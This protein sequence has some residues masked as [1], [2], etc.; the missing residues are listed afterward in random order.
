MGTEPFFTLSSPF[1]IVILDDGKIRIKEN[2]GGK[3]RFL[4]NKIEPKEIAR[5]I[6]VMWSAGRR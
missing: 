1:D 4:E 3:F 5:Q 6:D 2:P